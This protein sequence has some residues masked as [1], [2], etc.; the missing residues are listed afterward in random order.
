MVACENQLRIAA[1][2][3]NSGLMKDTRRFLKDDRFFFVDQAHPM[4]PNARQSA[5]GDNLEEAVYL[6]LTTGRSATRKVGK[7]MGLMFWQPKSL[8]ITYAVNVDGKTIAAGGLESVLTSIYHDF[9][10]IQKIA[11]IFVLINSFFFALYGNR[12]L[13][14][15]YFKPLKR[16]AKRAESYQDEDILYFSVRKEDNEFSALS[17]ALNKML[18]RIADDKRLLKETIDSLQTANRDL[19]R[20]QNDVIR[21]DKLATVGRLT[22]GIAHE[23]GNP[24]GI[25]LGYLDLLK[26]T[27]LSPDERHDFIARSEKEITRINHIIRQLLDMS[28]TSVDES[29]PISIHQLLRDLVS[30]FNYQPLAQAITFE[31]TLGAADDFVFADPDR[32]RQV[33][34]NILLN[35]VDAVNSTAVT[36]AR[37]KIRSE[38]VTGQENDVNDANANFI[39]VTIQD[40]GPGIEPNHLPHV[41]DPFFT[42]KQPGKGTGL[43]L[44]V[45]FMIVEKIGGHIAASSS[46]TSGTVFEIW[47]PLTKHHGANGIDR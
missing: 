15:I 12:Q 29:K 23:I 31:S 6:T 37:I 44:S 45:S 41:F 26:P 7:T 24:I 42:T 1:V 34:L 3:K 32:L 28:R 16:L 47:L 19:K 20:A 17:S 40:N 21:A 5:L 35:A 38:C 8:I 10:T 39:K 25:V 22:S 4:P 33:F 9:H 36:N 13:S 11:L 18:H 14:R 43:G 2:D 46:Q 30:V 27:D